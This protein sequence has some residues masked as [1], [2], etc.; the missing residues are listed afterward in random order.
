MIAYDYVVNTVYYKSIM[1]QHSIFREITPVRWG[2]YVYRF[3]ACDASTGGYYSVYE[4]GEKDYTV[5]LTSA[6]SICDE[7]KKGAANERTLPCEKYHMISQEFFDFLN[8]SIAHFTKYDEDMNDFYNKFSSQVDDFCASQKGKTP[9]RSMNVERKRSTYEILKKRLQPES[10]GSVTTPVT[11]PARTLG[12]RGIHMDCSSDYYGTTYL[13][14]VAPDSSNEESKSATYSSSASRDP[15]KKR[16][17]TEVPTPQAVPHLAS[18]INPQHVNPQHVHLLQNSLR[19]FGDERRKLLQENRELQDIIQ[20]NPILSQ[21]DTPVDDD[22]TAEQVSILREE[23]A[24]GG[25]YDVEAL[26]NNLAALSVQNTSR[27]G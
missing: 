25:D 6:S 9:W 14:N 3:T 19:V 21:I 13:G 22:L 7:C 1:V 18:R 4:K 12:S 2:S 8:T 20:S 27:L 16:K 5:S 24:K 26:I 11:S 23:L 10:E 15:H 17:C